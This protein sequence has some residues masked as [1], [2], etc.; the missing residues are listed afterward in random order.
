VKQYAVRIAPRLA[1]L[2][3]FLGHAAN[4][5]RI[6]FVDQLD[7]IIYDTR[8]RLTMPRVLDERI[9]ILDIDE[10]SLAAPAGAVAVGPRLGRGPGREALR[11][12][13][14][15]LRRCRRS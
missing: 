11:Q 10:K 6:A 12:R 3:V 5:Y 7:R 2:A 1:V 13:A 9:V 8:L 15:T 4:F 14:S